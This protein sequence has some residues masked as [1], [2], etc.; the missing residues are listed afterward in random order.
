MTVGFM[1]FKNVI[2]FTFVIASSEQFQLQRKLG[3]VTA[4]TLFHTSYHMLLLLP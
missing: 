3:K 1:Y 4:K 2:I